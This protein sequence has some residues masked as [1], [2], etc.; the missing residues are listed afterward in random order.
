MPFFTNR[1]QRPGRLK[2]PYP[3]VF[4]AVLCL[5]TNL[6]RMQTIY[7]VRVKWTSVP[8]LNNK[9][10]LCRCASPAFSFVLHQYSFHGGL[11]PGYCFCRQAYSSRK[12]RLNGIPHF[13]CSRL[14]RPATKTKLCGHQRRDAE[15]RLSV[16]VMGKSKLT[17]LAYPWKRSEELSTFFL[18]FNHVITFQFIRKFLQ[19]S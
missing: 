8:I 6:L 1:C 4:R 9:S 7:L 15:A 17:E 13:F 12:F 3:A 2:N 19:K 16:L 10:A 5:H 14:H 11:T 18:I